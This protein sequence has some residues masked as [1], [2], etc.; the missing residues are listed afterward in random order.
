[1]NP[2]TPSS[3]PVIPSDGEATSLAVRVFQL[4]TELQAT[5]SDLRRLQIR[6]EARA[7]AAAAAILGMDDI[8]LAASELIARAERLIAKNNPAQSGGRGKK[9]VNPGLTVSRQV[10]SDMRATHAGLDDAQFERRVQEHHE[11]GV[12]ITRRSLRLGP[13]AP[14]QILQSGKMEWYS[15]TRIVAAA[16]EA[17]GGTIDLDPASCPAANGVVRATQFFTEA[18]N[19]LT[20][21]WHG[22][23]WM[24]PPFKRGVCE[25]FIAKLISEPRVDAW[26]CLVSNTTESRWGHRLLNAADVVC[27]P[28]E[29]L[30]FWG[31]DACPVRDGKPL[32]GQMLAGRFNR[33]RSAGIT[34]F[35]AAFSDIGWVC[36]GVHG[37]AA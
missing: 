9:T 2:H 25:L 24:N 32:F 1:M 8:R 34:R 18:D 20:K 10:L 7:A 22:R 6:D 21:D 28:N 27:F 13:S 16:R 35:I 12:P 30:S 5:T 29:R 17:L 15:P 3:L 33:D 36:R 31:P 37:R 19:G 11:L 26:V 14:T 4:R 23:V